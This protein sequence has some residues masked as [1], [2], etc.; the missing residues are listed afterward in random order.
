MTEVWIKSPLYIFNPVSM[1]VASKRII[2]D[3]MNNE[4]SNLIFQLYACVTVLVI[5]CYKQR[6]VQEV[7]LHSIQ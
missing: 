6:T 7:S 5:Q 1:D 2:H 4:V 3:C